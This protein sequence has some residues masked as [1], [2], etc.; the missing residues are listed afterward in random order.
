ME[1]F[2]GNNGDCPPPVEHGSVQTNLMRYAA[3]HIV[4]LSQGD[5]L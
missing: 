2:V 5:L 4:T 3:I 1:F